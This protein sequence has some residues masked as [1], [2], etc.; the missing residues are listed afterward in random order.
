MAAMIVCFFFFFIFAKVKYT[1][2]YKDSEDP[3]QTPYNADL[4]L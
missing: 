2:P 1:I 3:D 4:D